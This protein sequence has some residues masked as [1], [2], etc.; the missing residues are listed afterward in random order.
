M[1]GTVFFGALGHPAAAGD[2]PTVF[3]HGLAQVMPWQVAAYLLAALA[4]LA[5]PRTTARH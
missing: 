5:L 1:L 4:M 3:G 2:A